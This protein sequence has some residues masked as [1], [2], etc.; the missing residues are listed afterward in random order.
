MGLSQNGSRAIGSTFLVE[1]PALHVPNYSYRKFGDGYQFA[2]YGSFPQEW[3]STAEFVHLDSSVIEYI[4][5]V[6]LG[7]VNIS[8]CRFTPWTSKLNPIFSGAGARSTVNPP[9][10]S[11]YD[12]ESSGTRAYSARRL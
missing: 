7:S 3:G 11:L 4:R 6:Q 8:R 10:V 9:S 1:D 12:M 2:W 5:D